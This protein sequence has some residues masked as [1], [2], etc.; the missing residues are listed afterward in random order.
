M[1]MDHITAQW[2]QISFLGQIDFVQ[3][4]FVSLK[5][6]NYC[7]QPIPNPLIYIMPYPPEN[8]SPDMAQTEEGAYFWICMICLEYKPL[9]QIALYSYLAT[10][11]SPPI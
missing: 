1:N 10:G 9:Q 5:F 3:A 7:G 2:C 6:I 8:E 4:H 11:F